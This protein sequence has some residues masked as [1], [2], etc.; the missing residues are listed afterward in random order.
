[1]RGH[2]PVSFH[3]MMFDVMKV[4]R[5]PGMSQEGIGYVWKQV[6][7]PSILRDQDPAHANVLMHHESVRSSVRNLHHGVKDAM[8]PREVV[9]EEQSAWY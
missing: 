9:V 2:L 3:V 7:E 8:K 4:I 5:V 6:I 1:M